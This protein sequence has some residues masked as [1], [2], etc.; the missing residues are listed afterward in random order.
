MKKNF[1][2]YTAT[3]SADTPAAAGAVED[4]VSPTL[5]EIKPPISIRTANGLHMH[6]IQTGWVA[7]H[8]NHRDLFGPAGTRLAS[9]LLDPRWT[10]WL[11]IL[12]WVIE[13]PEGVIVID[14]GETSRVVEPDFFNCDPGSNF[15][16]RRI[17]RFLVRPEEEIGAQM[18]GLGIAPESVRWV[19]QTHLHCDHAGGLDAFPVSE[20]VTSH[21]DF[22]VSQG[23][24][25]CRYPSWLKPH[26][27][28]FVPD[29]GLS[30]GR[31]MTLT[32]SGDV[33]IVPTPGHALGHQSVIVADGEVTY[34]FAGDASFDDRQMRAGRVAGICADVAQA[35]TTLA[36]IRRFC[37]DRPTVYLPTH[38]R[39]APQRFQDAAPTRV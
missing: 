3:A 10:E 31:S 39:L 13:H 12:T 26:F 28:E 25:P 17:L 27:A 15:V 34:F 20:I 4:A 32:R 16:F 36:Q 7:V 37:A 23:A 18:Q 22:P 24:L 21:L 38:D 30:F 11:P 29:I 1:H 9:I 14:T 2:R 5:P 6:A 33:K 8:P 35:R 19:V